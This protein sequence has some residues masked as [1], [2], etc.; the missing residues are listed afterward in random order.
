MRFVILGVGNLLLNDEGIGVHVVRAS[1][2][3]PL[4]DGV[5]VVDEGTSPDAL[6]LTKGADKLIIIDAVKGGGK[7][8]SI[9]RFTPEDIALKPE[10]FKSAHNI[11]LIESLRALEDSPREVVIIGVEPKDISW[12]LEL[13]P[14]LQARVFK[15]VEVVLKEFESI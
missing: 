7:P 9:Y 11:G 15:I 4:P 5:E 2:E 8:G 14:Q 13:S 3:M 10:A 6:Y 12:G 1:Q